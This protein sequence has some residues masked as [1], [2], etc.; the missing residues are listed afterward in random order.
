MYKYKH[1]Y[2]P[3]L[4][5]KYRDGAGLCMGSAASVVAAV[6]LLHRGNHQAAARLLCVFSEIEGD[7]CPFCVVVDDLVVVVPVH[8]L[9][10]LQS[11]FYDA[12]KTDVP[13]CHGVVPEL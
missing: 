8:V 9:W 7:S 5:D 1:K 3:T 2:K 12:D 4:A 10:W 13:S 11:I 6:R